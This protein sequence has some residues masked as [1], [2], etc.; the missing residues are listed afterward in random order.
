[1]SSNNIKSTLRDRILVYK[2]FIWIWVKNLIMKKDIVLSLMI[3]IWL[4][5]LQ[6]KNILYT[7]RRRV[8]CRYFICIDT[9]TASMQS[10]TLLKQQICWIAE[11][12]VINRK[13]FNNTHHS[14]LRGKDKVLPGIQIWKMGRIFILYSMLT[15]NGGK[16]RKLLFTLVL[17]FIKEWLQYNLLPNQHKK[18]PKPMKHFET[19]QKL[20]WNKNLLPIKIPFGGFILSDKLI[21]QLLN[22]NKINEGD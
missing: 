4:S 8:L 1:M 15:G 3:C 18:Y 20:D 9:T 13:L 5:Q 16:Y 14:V 19:V 6:L 11:S 7:Y 21:I 12:I 22:V 2:N 10:A 17:I